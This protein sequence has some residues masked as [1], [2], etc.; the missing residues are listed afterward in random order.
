[1]LASR[2]AKAERGEVAIG[3]ARL[4]T[5]EVV[6]DPDEQARHVVRLVFDTFGRLGDAQWALR[7]LADYQV[8]LP[9]RVHS[10]VAN[11]EIEW[12][13]VSTPTGSTVLL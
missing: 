9:V 2:L 5:G 3:Y 4:P 6:L 10:G 7:Y 1:M 11:G 13:A 8:E 12:L